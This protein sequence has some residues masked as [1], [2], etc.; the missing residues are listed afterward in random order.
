MCIVCFAGTFALV[1]FVCR[2]MNIQTMYGYVCVY[3]YIYI[4]CIRVS[5]FMVMFIDLCVCV[6]KLAGLPVSQRNL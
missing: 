6:F 5:Y 4:L 2:F 1:S 3:A